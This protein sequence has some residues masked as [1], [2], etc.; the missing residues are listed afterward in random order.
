M[1]IVD[2]G[3]DAIDF[4]NA[5][6]N[7]EEESNEV[8]DDLFPSL[9]SKSIDAEKTTYNPSLWTPA[10]IE[11][12]TGNAE[13]TFLE[14]PLLLKSTYTEA[15]NSSGTRDPNG[16]PLVTSY[17]KCFLGTVDYIW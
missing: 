15:T 10:E 4:I 2:V 14:H 3:E 5:L 17:N 1:S 13:S 16:E 6:Y 11:T 12:A 9:I 8:K 7:A